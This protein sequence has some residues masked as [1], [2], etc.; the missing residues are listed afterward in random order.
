MTRSRLP[1]RRSK[2]IWTG[3][4]AT[5]FDKFDRLYIFRLDLGCELV[6]RFE[7]NGVKFISDPCDNDSCLFNR[8]YN[9]VV[10]ISCTNLRVKMGKIIRYGLRCSIWFMTYFGGDGVRTS[11]CAGVKNFG[12]SLLLSFSSVFVRSVLVFS[13]CSKIALMVATLSKF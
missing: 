13:D 9:D 2:H 3:T 11:C 1:L 8:V 4:D 7:C 12:T 6:L 10:F 5:F